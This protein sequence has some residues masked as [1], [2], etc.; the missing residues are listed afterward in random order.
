MTIE[1]AKFLETINSEMG[2]QDL[3]I[4]ENYSGRGMYGRETAGVVV[5]SQTQLLADVLNYFVNR[6]PVALSEESE[7]SEEFPNFRVDNMGHS[8]ILY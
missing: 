4:R 6:N 7:E 2:N 3:D 8:V 1:Q 5:D